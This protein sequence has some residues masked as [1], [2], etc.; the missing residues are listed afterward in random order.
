M[1][2]FLNN[3]TLE[4]SKL[5]NNIGITNDS[6]EIYPTEDGILQITDLL[7]QCRKNNG[8]TYVIGNGGSAAIAGHAV[9]DMLNMGKL[10]AITLHDSATITC[11]SN[12]YGYEN[13][14]QHQLKN[15]IRPNDVLV[16]ISSSGKSQN[17]LNAASIAKELNAKVITLSGFSNNN[18]LRTSGDINVW[19][20]SSD[21]GLVE[22]GH[23]FIL[24]N[25]TD[26]LHFKGDAQ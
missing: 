11:I 8:I 18:P 4:F 19:L 12:D 3:R 13:V 5:I 1:K 21:Y 6:S 15:L 16:A 9:I 25:I 17:I 22:I 14:Y 10:R 24:H 23:A 7:N 26:R 20:D 2:L